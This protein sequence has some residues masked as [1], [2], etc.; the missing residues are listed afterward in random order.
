MVIE[1]TGVFATAFRTNLGYVLLRL[2]NSFTKTSIVQCPG[3]KF[4][5]AVVPLGSATE[6]TVSSFKLFHELYKD[7]DSRLM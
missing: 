3:S 7:V 6:I 5:L 2:S 4:A 1:L